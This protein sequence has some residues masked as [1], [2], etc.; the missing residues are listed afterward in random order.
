MFFKPTMHP[1]TCFLR[2]HSR[3]SMAD[4]ESHLLKLLWLGW[5]PIIIFI[6]LPL[7]ET[8]NFTCVAGILLVGDAKKSWQTLEHSSNGSNFVEAHVDLCRQSGKAAWGTQRWFLEAQRSYWPSIGWWQTQVNRT[9]AVN[10]VQALCGVKPQ[11]SLKF[12]Q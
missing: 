6:R 11:S 10:T 12:G 2:I 7:S 3:R 1:P 4:T 5:R 9:I 8:D